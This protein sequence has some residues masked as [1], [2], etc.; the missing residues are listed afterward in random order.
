MT[1]RPTPSPT[2]SGEANHRQRG[3]CATG[4]A[5]VT[6]PSTPPPAP[7]WGRGLTVLSTLF[8]ALL[9]LAAG[10]GAHTLAWN[11]GLQRLAEAAD[12]RLDI[13]AA[14]VD[15]QLSRFDYLP[16]LLETTP[17]VLDLLQAADK[18]ER[19]ALRDDAN[20]LLRALNA[21][22]GAEMLY[23]LD[24]QGLTIAAGDWDRQGSPYGMNLAFRPYVQ[25]ALTQGRG[26]FYGVGVTSGQAGYYLS[27]ALK[28]DGR[29]LGLATAKVSLSANEH[30]WSQLPGAQLLIDER[31]V[32]ILSSV[33]AWRY[34]PVQTLTAATRDEVARSRPYGNSTL[35]PLAWRIVSRLPDGRDL[36]DV[37]GRRYLASRHTLR[38]SRWRLVALD[39]LAPLQVQAVQQGLIGSLA[40]LA[41]W[42]LSGL[43]LARR[44]AMQQRLRVADEL[45]ATHDE[46]EHK[47][48]QRTAE[49]QRSNADLAAEVDARARTEA[50]LRAAQQELVHNSKM[51]ALGQMSAGMMHELNQPLA[52]MRTLSDN[53][54]V[55][56]DK[57]RLPEVDGNLQRL[58]HLVDRLSKL[59]AQL[60]LFAYKPGRALGQVRLSTVVTQAQFLVSPRLD[61]HGLAIDVQ[62]DPPT[63]AVRADEARLEQVL[64]NLL[65]NGIEATASGRS[66]DGPLRLTAQAAQ[67][68]AGHGHEG[69]MARITVEDPGPGIPADILPR[70]FEPF[71]TSKPAGTGL[72]LGLML[73]AH[74][75]R[76]FGGSLH[77]ENVPGGG[78]RFVLLLPLAPA[79]ASRNGH[80]AAPVAPAAGPTKNHPEPPAPP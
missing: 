45:R 72:G 53:A 65:G 61:E 63:L 29:V 34:R 51:A 39:D 35:A 10:W 8:G 18:P 30:A 24:V 6:L 7:V 42:L 70:L 56:L 78:A 20:Q 57:G 71:T 41:L 47:V 32:A 21:T 54:R 25:E 44:R 22:A 2:R 13:S 52:A 15:A 3:A 27:Y 66:H 80:P 9:V 5:A 49:L 36:M 74:I 37:E 23:V 12:H 59:T 58:T 77:G 62:I 69:A 73:S 50:E 11:R 64:V 79:G 76:E 67:A 68:D 40:V 14:S 55:L 75:A 31:G 26:R 16:S 46:L 48:V 19:T 60:K 38:E 33:P 17:A 28:R 1:A 43:W 4:L